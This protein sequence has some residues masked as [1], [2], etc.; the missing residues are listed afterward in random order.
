MAE[1]TPYPFAALVRRML[2][3]LERNR[4]IFDLPARRFFPGDPERDLAVR[5]HGRRAS[6]P[7][8]PAAGPHTQMAQNLV[9]SWL[10]GSRI[11][12][13]KTV[14]IR[15]ELQIP[16]PCID[17]RTVGFN[18]EWSQ[19]LKLEQSLEEYVKGAMLIEM[20]QAE[21][22][23]AGGSLEQA[24]GFGDV[25]YDISVG[26]DLAGIQSERVLAFLRGMLDAGPVVERLRRQIPGEHRR[27]RE[28]AFPTRLSDTVTLS[29]FH[30]CPPDEI[31][32]ILEFL[33]R[34]L[35]LHCVVKLNPMLLGR[36]ET[37][38]LLHEV[39]GY[40]ELRVP[41]S[42]FAR[43]TRW[44]QAVEIVGRLAETARSL[45]LGF[46]VKLTNTLIVENTTDF[47]PPEEK[48]VYLSGPPLHVLAMHL[49]RRFRRTFGPELP[50]SFSAGI[51]RVNFA[52]A[53]AL[54]LVP[55][56]V[57][58]DLLK[59]GGY[60]RLPAYYAEL[61]RRMGAAGAGS[62][63]DF[64]LKAHGQGEAALEAAGIGREDPRHQACRKALAAGG[65]L[66]AAVGGEEAY[67]RWVATAAGLNT[68]V[69]VEA[70][71]R[72]PRYHRE[73]NARPPRKIGRHLK[74]FDCVTCDLCVPVCPNDANF[75]FGDGPA[76]I[77]VVRLE[78]GDGGWRWHRQPPLVLSERHQ[79]GNLADFCNDCG[80][81]DV[82]C[83]E[84]GGPYV[85]K[86]RFF[87]REEDWRRSRELD[88]FFLRRGREGDL[89]LGRFGGRELTLEV[90][91]DRYI[92]SGAEFRVSFRSSDPEGTLR[93]EGDEVDLTW[94]FIMDYLRRAVL[95]AAQVSY[96]NS[97][98]AAEGRP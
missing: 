82:F 1:L 17:M 92:Y 64:V 41:D 98:T 42:A 33:M 20:L 73:H 79:I 25:L 60:G 12:E 72:D 58:S 95:D 7:L 93:G 24:P 30:G 77:P 23:Q 88:G 56:T 67:Q 47:L 36:Q 84:D 66:A 35:G 28:L 90:A 83:P 31:E 55:I 5:F 76:E 9:L 44:Q 16:R 6:S 34:E 59:K 45:G 49:V 13:L 19:E 46:G 11:L 71:T 4:S 80:N 39:L 57:C 69:Y 53:A 21:M 52:D 43:D 91:R 26:Y 15:D 85:M 97:L 54:G 70:V 40:R 75:T 78:R 63:G 51:D 14:Q 2:G 94:C 81:C 86:P 68:E 18:A 74:L 62:L 10:G 65:D 8:G 50:I 48:E 29:T 96:V 22:R 87:A 32:G 61:A 37:D 38:H 3:E 27:L 89:V